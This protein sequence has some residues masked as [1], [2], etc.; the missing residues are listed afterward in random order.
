MQ[1]ENTCPQPISILPGD[2]H[3]WAVVLVFL[4]WWALLQP[5][6]DRLWDQRIDRRQAH[7]ATVCCASSQALNCTKD[8]LCLI[9]FIMPR[10]K[11]SKV[12]QARPSKP[13][14]ASKQ[15]VMYRGSTQLRSD[16]SHN[17]KKRRRE[18][19]LSSKL[20]STRDL[21]GQGAHVHG[22]TRHWAG[23]TMNTAKV[24]PSLLSLASRVSSACRDMPNPTIRAQVPFLASIFV[25]CSF[26]GCDCLPS[27]PSLVRSLL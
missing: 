9:R 3:N 25:A 12:R 8:P 16:L 17:C 18:G 13:L 11:E 20:A 5:Y 22:I 4:I 10:L 7:T 14:L 21:A 27:L 1:E 2:R 26:P 6:P 24:E 23:T 19:D 15:I